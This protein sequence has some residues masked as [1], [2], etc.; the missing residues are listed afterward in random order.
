MKTLPPKRDYLDD[1]AALEVDVLLTAIIYERT[2]AS[3]AKLSA[4]DERIQY[5]KRKVKQ[6]P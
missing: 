4:L 1:Y 6:K 3:I 5:L 2:D